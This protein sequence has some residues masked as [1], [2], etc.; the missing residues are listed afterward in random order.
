MIKKFFY[1]VLK[2][3]LT[4]LQSQKTKH[5]KD[6][7]SS[8]RLTQYITVDATQSKSTMSLTRRQHWVRTYFYAVFLWRNTVLSKAVMFIQSLTKFL[9]Y[10]RSTFWQQH[11][12]LGD[13]F[14]PH[15]PPLKKV[16][17]I[18]YSAQK[19]I[20]CTPKT[21]YCVPNKIVLCSK[22]FFFQ[23]KNIYD[24]WQNTICTANE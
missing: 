5:S 11:A 13:T 3:L 10:K 20:Y 19:K 4:T 18:L 2:G 12:V 24:T 7:F 22:I 15:P 8:P 1:Q 21:L 16:I 23:S 9:N 17:R 6:S 14:T